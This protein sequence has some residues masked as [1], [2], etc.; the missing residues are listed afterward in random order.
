MKKQPAQRSAAPAQKHRAAS[1]QRAPATKISKDTKPRIFL[2][3]LFVRFVLFV[4]AYYLRPAGLTAVR[5]ILRADFFDGNPDREAPLGERFF[6]YIVPIFRL[7]A[8]LA[9]PIEHYVHRLR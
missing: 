1:Q 5:S 7:A 8:D 3:D 4:V 9:V 2:S 6:A